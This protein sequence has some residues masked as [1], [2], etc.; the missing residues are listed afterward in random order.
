MILVKLKEVVES[1][2]GVEVVDCVLSVRNIM[3]II[4]IE[5]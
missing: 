3:I 1:N 4:I 5:G 2:L